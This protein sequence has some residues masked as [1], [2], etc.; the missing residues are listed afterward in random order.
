MKTNQSVLIEIKEKISLFSLI[1]MVIVLFSSC[2]KY[3]EGGKINHS[4]RNNN[5]EHE[6]NMEKAWKNGE[7]IEYINENPQITEITED[8]IFDK[9][10][11][12]TTDGSN[13]TYHGTWEFNHHG[14]ILKINMVGVIIEYEIKKL[15]SGTN[16][17]MIWEYSKNGNLYRCLFT[18]LL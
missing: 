18:S 13:D 15:T 17:E 11:T 9:N 16:R 10:G 8:W 3:E 4:E 6:W 5:I 14:K 2:R 1:F 7:I 12:C